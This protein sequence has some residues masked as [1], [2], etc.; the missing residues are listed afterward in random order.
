MKLIP[1]TTGEKGGYYLD[2]RLLETTSHIIVSLKCSNSVNIN[3]EF[4]ALKREG[5]DG[6]HIL[7]SFLS[8]LQL[9]HQL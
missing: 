6:V 7:F 2:V 8:R 5:Q 4:S 1:Q 9:L 3:I